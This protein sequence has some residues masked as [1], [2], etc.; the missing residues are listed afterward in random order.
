[1]DLKSCCPTSFFRKLDLLASSFY[2][3]DDA[4]VDEEFQRILT[5]DEAIASV[6]MAAGWIEA[7]IQLYQGSVV[8]EELP[9]WFA[10]GLTQSLRMNRSKDEAL[11]FA[12]KQSVN[13]ALSLLIG[14][15]LLDM[16]S[17]D[18]ALEH[19]KGL[20]MED[21]DIGL[22]A[23]FLLASILSDEGA[24]DEAKAL[25]SSQNRLSDSVFGK[26]LL[27]RIVH[28]EGDDEG[29]AKLYFQIQDQSLEAKSF[30]AKAAF[31]KQRWQKARLLTEELLYQQPGSLAL[32]DNLFR[33]QLTERLQL[34]SQ[35][36]IER[37]VAGSESSARGS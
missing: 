33:I 26:E 3:G 20:S 18:A 36:E 30:L 11:S 9:D 16:G 8:P 4:V 24:F 23:A 29:A 1:M 31:S 7:A 34:F 15:I 32:R 27:A 13:P 17:P 25:I 35:E 6:F 21:T 28:L 37:G 10:F 2:S 5:S 22:R 12:A 14:Q 19:L